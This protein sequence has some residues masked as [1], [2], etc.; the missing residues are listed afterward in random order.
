MTI[1]RD[2]NIVIV[3]GVMVLLHLNASKSKAKRCR[4]EAAFGAT[5]AR[6]ATLAHTMLT[7]G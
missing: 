7:A 4:R 1:V 2:C 5:S 6:A 3:P